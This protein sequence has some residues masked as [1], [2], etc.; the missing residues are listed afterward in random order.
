MWR[1]GDGAPQGH[2]D[3]GYERERDVAGYQPPRYWQPEA[4]DPYAHRL[5]YL[6]PAAVPRPRAGETQAAQLGAGGSGR[7]SQPQFWPANPTQRPQEP[8]R[9]RPA[10][11]TGGRAS[12]L[13][14]AVAVLLI[15]V[16]LFCG[17][18]AWWLHSADGAHRAVAPATAVVDR[19][20]ASGAPQTRHRG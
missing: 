17:V 16:G 14:A 20:A 10:P 5:A 7:P 2:P 19:H 11:A 6:W 15:F 9:A 13:Q 3:Q 8:P 12:D 1:S 18:G 4:Y